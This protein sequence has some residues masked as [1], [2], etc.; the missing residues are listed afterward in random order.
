MNCAGEWTGV[1]A[2]QGTG[3]ELESEAE[4]GERLWDEVESKRNV[5]T[6][7]INP[8]K[9]TAYLRQCKVLDEEDEDEVLNSRQLTSRKGRASRLLDMLRC[10]GSRGY[11]AFLESLE[12]YYAELYRLLTGEEPTRRCSVLVGESL[13]LAGLTSV[14]APYHGHTRKCQLSQTQP[15][16]RVCVCVC[17][18]VNACVC[19]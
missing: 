1:E 13:A 14:P 19:D 16:S 11:E 18:C 10:R 7:S 4:R 6:R 9:L 15:A 8:A 5:L 17:L 3:L 2:V 12:L